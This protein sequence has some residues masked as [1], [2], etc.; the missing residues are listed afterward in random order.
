MV[1]FREYVI[2]IRSKRTDDDAFLYEELPVR[3]PSTPIVG[4]DDDAFLYE[5]LQC[6]LCSCLAIRFANSRQIG[7]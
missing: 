6:Y 4:N 7:F 3:L 1:V 2:V 5:E